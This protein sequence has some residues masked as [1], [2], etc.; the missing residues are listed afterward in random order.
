MW[1]IR[2]EDLLWKIHQRQLFC[3]TYIKIKE[4]DYQ[5]KNQQFFFDNTQK[6]KW[7]DVKTW[8]KLV[9]VFSLLSHSSLVY[10]WNFYGKQFVAIR[11]GSSFYL[12]FFLI[13][14]DDHK[15]PE[16]FF[17]LLD[18]ENWKKLW[19]NLISDAQV[20]LKKAFNGFFFLSGYEILKKVSRKEIDFSLFTTTNYIRNA[21]SYWFNPQIWV[22]DREPSLLIEN[23][24]IFS[25]TTV[26]YLLSRI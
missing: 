12:F 5:I 25:L 18:T 19:W 13:W 16:Y 17:F 8:W 11:F 3:Q 1:M 4:F 26:I 20:K 24:F 21:F 7:H 10:I 6:I 15:I 23:H 9:T 22:E 2:F 14:N